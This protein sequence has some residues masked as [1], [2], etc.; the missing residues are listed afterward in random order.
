MN[1]TFHF[2]NERREE[3]RYVNKMKNKSVTITLKTI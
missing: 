2:Y 1:F 3:V